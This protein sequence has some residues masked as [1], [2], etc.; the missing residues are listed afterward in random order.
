LPVPPRS[1]HQQEIYDVQLSYGGDSATSSSGHTGWPT[2]S[3]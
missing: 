2:Y 3:R 1:Y